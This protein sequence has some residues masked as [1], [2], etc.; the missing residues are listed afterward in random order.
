MAWAPTCGNVKVMALESSTYHTNHQRVY[1][2]R[3]KA[4]NYPCARECGR[5][6]TQWAQVH[7]T[8]GSNPDEYT[9]MC[10]S[11]HAK[12]DGAIPPSQLG[13]KPA[14]SMFTDEQAA[15]MRALVASGISQ[16]EVARRYGCVR[17]VVWRVVHGVAYNR[18]GS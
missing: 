16:A 1:R 5:Q 3:G 15:E 12:Y 17:Q 6:S 2:T 7:G 14:N 10:R 8:D 13:K 18:G 11:C 9:P 4:R